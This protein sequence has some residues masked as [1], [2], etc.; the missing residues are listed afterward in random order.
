MSLS[1]NT[2]ESLFD[3]VIKCGFWSGEDE[4]PALKKHSSIVSFSCSDQETGLE[5]DCLTACKLVA[6]LVISAHSS[7][8]GISSG[9]SSFRSRRS[10]HS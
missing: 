3:L 7:S 10:L 4:R 8:T 1:L 6:K 9:A 2:I 5:A